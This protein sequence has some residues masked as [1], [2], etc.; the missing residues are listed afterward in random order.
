MRYEMFHQI[1]QKHWV[2]FVEAISSLTTVSFCNFITTPT[3]HV[4]I[5]AWRILWIIINHYLNNLQMARVCSQRNDTVAHGPLK[6]VM[7]NALYIDLDPSSCIALVNIRIISQ[8][9][10]VGFVSN[11]HRARGSKPG[12]GWREYFMW[13]RQGSGNTL[14]QC[15]EDIIIAELVGGRASK[16]F[17]IENRTTRKKWCESVKG[18]YCHEAIIMRKERNESGTGFQWNFTLGQLRLSME[19]Y[20]QGAKIQKAMHP[21]G[22]AIRVTFANMLFN[23]CWS[24]SC[25]NWNAARFVFKLYCS[26]LQ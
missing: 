26:P 14:L 13:N 22:F 2:R 4:P 24:T 16:A 5:M 3:I 19:W 12:S 9:G 8:L 23:L 17:K 20:W 25:W 1:S 21:Q 11:F 6:D 10:V 7:T 15:Q 18:R